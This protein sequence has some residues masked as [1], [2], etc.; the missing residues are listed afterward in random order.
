MAT[1]NRP[2]DGR[3][4]SKEDLD[5]ILKRGNRVVFFD[6]T[7][8]GIDAGRLVMEVRLLSSGGPRCWCP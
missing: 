6:V 4:I 5:A 3:G 7:V 8:A 1:S 2:A